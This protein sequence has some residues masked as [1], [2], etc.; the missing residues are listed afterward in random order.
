MFRSILKHSLAVIALSLFCSTLAHAIPAGSPVAG[1]YK[2]TDLGGALYTGRAS[3]S[4]GAAGNTINGAFPGAQI[5]I[6]QPRHNENFNANYADGHS[7]AIKG[8]DT[9]T[10]APQFTVFGPGKTLEI[11]KIGANGGFYT[12]MNEC[13][14]IPTD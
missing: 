9:K 14:G 10:S 1:T 7:K 8:T 13:Q 2:S 3:Q 4:W 6:V 11:W 12:G 5:Q